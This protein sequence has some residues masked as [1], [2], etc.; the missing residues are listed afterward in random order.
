ME[1]SPRSHDCND[2]SLELCNSSMAETGIPHQHGGILVE[3]VHQPQPDLYSLQI[4]L[5]RL[6]H[7]VTHAIGVQLESADQGLDL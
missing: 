5:S 3:E 6:K 7:Q 2:V 4:S 1:R